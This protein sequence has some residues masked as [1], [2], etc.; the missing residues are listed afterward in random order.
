MVTLILGKAF[1]GL[2]DVAFNS[3]GTG[4]GAV[5]SGFGPL[6]VG[7]GDDVRGRFED[8]PVGAATRSGVFAGL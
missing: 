4:G 6:T 3:F 2:E 8:C 5:L 1:R 7:T